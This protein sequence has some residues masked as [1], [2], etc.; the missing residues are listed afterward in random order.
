MTNADFKEAATTISEGFT[1]F[2]TGLNNAF[3]GTRSVRRMKKILKALKKGNVGKLMKGVSGFVD[4]IVKLASAGIPLYDDNGKE[5]GK[6]PLNNEVFVASA[7][8]LANG[9]AA[10]LSKLEDEFGGSGRQ[11]KRLKKIIKRLSKAGIDKLMGSISSFIEPVMQIA[12]G[13]IEVN[14]KSI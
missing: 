4:A 13:Y 6:Q 8:V 11:S 3:D 1:T 12:S 14:G 7:T 2:L 5:I 10:F 9:F